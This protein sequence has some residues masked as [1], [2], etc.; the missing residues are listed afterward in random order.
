MKICY[1]VI[2]ILLSLNSFA[3]N[4]GSRFNLSGKTNL[5]DGEKITLQ[6]YGSKDS[7]FVKDGSFVFRGNLKEP[8]LA[9]L[10]HGQTNI[11]DG[12]E[13]VR[14]FLEPNDLHITVLNGQFF[15]A[16]L[17]GSQT[18]SDWDKIR[19]KEE[20]DQIKDKIDGL[21]RAIKEKGMSDSLK[22]ELNLRN[23]EGSRLFKV[24]EKNSLAFVRNNPNS[25]LSPYLLSS[26]SRSLPK[27]SVQFYYRSFSAPVLN[28][29]WGRF[30]YKELGYE[31]TS[32]IGQPAPDFYAKLA[33]GKTISLAGFKSKKYVLL[34]FWGTWCVH[35]R[36][37]SPD[38]IKMYKKYESKGLEIVSI[39][40]DNDRKLWQKAI[41]DDQT[42]LW[43]HILLIDASKSAKGDNLVVQYSVSA[44]PTFILID[45]EGEIVGRYIGEGNDFHVN[46][47]N[48]LAEIFE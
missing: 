18:Q 5:K 11:F 24:A 27:D 3:Q 46:L 31:E 14:V 35:C 17:L 44:F 38:M 29:A 4:E 9:S 43:K 21:N 39:A 20:S 19:L 1:V 42:G 22:A 28:S 23:E 33:N 25:Y 13:S 15:K 12:P 8:S 32:K 34:D 41:V 26:L 37:L 6:Y 16:K 45:R 40:T 30:I 48:K 7:V 47:K 36:A 10:K 2:F